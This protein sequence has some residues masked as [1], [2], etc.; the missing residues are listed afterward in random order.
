MTSP[1]PTPAV[2]QQYRE[3]L[4]ECQG[5]S[6]KIS[7]LEMDRNEHVLVEETLRPLDPKRRAYRLIGEVLVERTVEEVLPSVKLNRENV[8]SSKDTVSAPNGRQHHLLLCLAEC[9][10]LSS[11]LAALADGKVNCNVTRTNGRTTETSCGDQSK[12]QSARS[13]GE[14]KWVSGY[15]FL[16]IYKY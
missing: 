9:S 13:S 7:A 15:L 8:S 14:I 12:V 2:I 11:L 5:L 4:E 16:K 6:A 3:L 1:A 10:F